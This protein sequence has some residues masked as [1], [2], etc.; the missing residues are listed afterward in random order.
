[1]KRTTRNA[2][3]KAKAVPRSQREFAARLDEARRIFD[4]PPGDIQRAT[5]AVGGPHVVD[6]LRCDRRVSIP[7]T[8]ALAAAEKLSVD[9]RW[10][11]TS[12]LSP[13]AAA[14]LVHADATVK[15]LLKTIPQPEGLSGVCRYC[16]CT[17]EHGCG[18]CEWVDKGHTICSACLDA[19][20]P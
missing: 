20:A 11:I 18:D 1:M 12:R 9:P 19:E 15:W 17:D 5:A 2:R 4:V 8:W 6:V 14:A 13:A 3:P 16:G 10:L 7:W